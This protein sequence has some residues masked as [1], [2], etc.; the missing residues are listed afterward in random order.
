MNDICVAF[1]QEE[2]RYV[3]EYVIP[4]DSEIYI[5]LPSHNRSS[6]QFR[7]ENS[8]HCFVNTRDNEDPRA[9]NSLTLAWM[10]RSIRD[11]LTLRASSGIGYYTCLVKHPRGPT[12]TGPLRFRIQGFG[13]RNRQSHPAMTELDL[14]ISDTT[15]MAR[16][17][18]QLFWCVWNAAR[19][20]DQTM[21]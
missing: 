7:L 12:S 20:G 1:L 10:I 13:R 16:T 14:P 3:G 9:R 5:K 2:G 17:G 6:H 15:I 8:E 11:P 4:A 21:S 18:S 19:K